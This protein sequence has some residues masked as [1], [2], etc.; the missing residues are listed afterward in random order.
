MDWIHGN[1]ESKE[2]NLALIEGEDLN[3]YADKLNMYAT[4]YKESA[5]NEFVKLGENNV[6]LVE[7]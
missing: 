7:T 4:L 1:I 5:I 2:K 6:E 3:L